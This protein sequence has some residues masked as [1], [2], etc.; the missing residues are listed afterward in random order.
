M[1][2]NSSLTWVICMSMLLSA[3]ATPVYERLEDVLVGM[4]KTQVLDRAGN[5]KRTQRLN[6]SDV[7]TYTYY[8]GDRHFERDVSFEAGHVVKINLSREVH[9]DPAEGELVIKDY[10]MLVNEKSTSKDSDTSE[11]K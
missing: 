4:D 8:I 5:P 2:V 6:D 3:C 7:W 1:T 10:E 9:Q 11:K